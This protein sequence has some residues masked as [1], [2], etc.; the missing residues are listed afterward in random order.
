MLGGAAAPPTQ[1]QEKQPIQ[2]LYTFGN[3]T[4]DGQTPLA[5]LWQAPGGIIVYGT[6]N[7]GGGAVC[8]CGTLFQL[9]PPAGGTGAWT[10]AQLHSFAGPHA[11]ITDGSN[12]EASVLRDAKGKFWGATLS[13]GGYGHGVLFSYNPSSLLTETVVHPFQG[14][15]DG[16][17]PSAALLLDKA[18]NLYGT[19]G[20]GSDANDFGTIFKYIPNSV[21]YSVLYNFKGGAAGAPPALAVRKAPA[22]YSS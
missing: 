1:A 15:T 20:G 2:V 6:T 3:N 8:A 21:E 14:G 5:G 19:T 16:S 12:P 7:L 11:S 22:R 17:A 9:S 4:K 13:G 10:E 18:G